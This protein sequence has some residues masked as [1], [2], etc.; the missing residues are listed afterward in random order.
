MKRSSLEGMYDRLTAEERYRLVVE[1]LARGDEQEAERLMNTCPRKTYTMNDLACTERLRASQLITMSV[2]AELIDMLGMLR[3]NEAHRE[4][5]KTQQE[6]LYSS[7]DWAVE[8]AALSYHQGW[9]DGCDHAWQAVGKHAPF[10]WNDK[11]SLSERA[12]QTVENIRPTRQDNA[13]DDPLA[14]LEGIRQGLCAWGKTVWEAF[15]RFCREQTDLEPETMIR[16]CFP[17]ALG[18]PSQLEE[19][20][21]SVQVTTQSLEDYEKMLV[22]TWRALVRD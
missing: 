1:A 6:D 13:H 15:S 22:H 17:A 10:P 20:V 11:T 12:K 19:A 5:I 16:A 7:L 2:C 9:D 18:L 3:L 21:G 8:Q 14:S 4:A